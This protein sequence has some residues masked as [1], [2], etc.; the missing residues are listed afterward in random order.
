[1]QKHGTRTVS[2]EQFMAYLGSPL[3]H[4][5]PRQGWRGEKL[6]LAHIHRNAHEQ[7]L[8]NGKKMHSLCSTFLLWAARTCSGFLQI[9]AISGDL[10]FQVLEHFSPESQAV[11][12]VNKE[13]KWLIY[14]NILHGIFSF[15]SLASM[16]YIDFMKTSSVCLH[17][18]FSFCSLSTYNGTAKKKHQVRIYYF[19]IRFLTKAETELLTQTI[20][21]LG[22]FYVMFWEK[23]TTRNWENISFITNF[24]F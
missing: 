8:G 7:T 9:G 23:L 24:Y 1:M 3:K 21:F 17:P 15:H 22:M 10:R 14:R 19:K 11:V 4:R 12:F 20:L 16:V 2:E 13:V 6:L 18:F 5:L